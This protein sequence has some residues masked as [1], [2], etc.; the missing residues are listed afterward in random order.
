M[1]RQPGGHH[2]LSGSKY[3][4]CW[5]EGAAG[6]RQL[7]AQRPATSADERLENAWCRAVYIDPDQ[8]CVRVF[9]CDCSFSHPRRLSARI[10]QWQAEHDWQDWQ[11]TYL[12]DRHHQLSLLTQRPYADA[13][14][15]GVVESV[16][17]EAGWWQRMADGSVQHLSWEPMDVG[18]YLTII[19]DGRC[20][21]V[22]VDGALLLVR[23]VLQLGLSG[24]L[25]LI[26]PSSHRPCPP[27]FSV[28][29][30]LVVDV[31]HQLLQLWS[32]VALPADAV[33]PGWTLS[34][35]PW[36]L[37]GH[38]EATGRPSDGYHQVTVAQELAP[39]LPR[40]PERREGLTS[41]VYE[42]VDQLVV[43]PSSDS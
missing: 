15:R 21:D 25:A 24:V 26:S 43:R 34:R 6:V 36:D 9:C 11:P 22:G 42:P 37:A 17:A 35:V 30:G 2:H 18:L 28:D 14:V 8:R 23:D 12:W 20:Y 5:P 1:V 10:A 7:L 41:V 32:A 29:Q 31:D 40:L 33:W 38:L 27:P 19:K 13:Y 3:G 4:L 16:T 39:Y